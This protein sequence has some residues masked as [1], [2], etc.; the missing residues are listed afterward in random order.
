M[1]LLISVFVCHASASYLPPTVTDLLRQERIASFLAEKPLP[2]SALLAGAAMTSLPSSF[3][4]P[5]PVGSHPLEA[6]PKGRV[7]VLE[8]ELEDLRSEME[9]LQR[10][11]KML[12]G[13]AVKAVKTKDE[14]NKSSRSAG[15]I[16]MNN[17]E[18]TET[19]QEGEKNESR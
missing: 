15:Q 9:E 11:I 19:N 14:G 6:V 13:K 8:D 4:S 7:E 16:V 17:K 2:T 12:K 3:P 1:L 5:L 18:K 10:E